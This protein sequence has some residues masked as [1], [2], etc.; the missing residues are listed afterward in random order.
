MILTSS[1]LPNPSR[2]SRF[3]TL[4]CNWRGRFSIC[5]SKKDDIFQWIPRYRYAPPPD[6]Q[7]Q[8]SGGPH[9][10]HTRSPFQPAKYVLSSPHKDGWNPLIPHIIAHQLLGKGKNHT[11]LG[12]DTQ[13]IQRYYSCQEGEESASSEETYQVFHAKK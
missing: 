3:S 4:S 6:K 8:I 13:A 1:I 2:S 11:C 5:K 10:L 12:N 9:H 7:H